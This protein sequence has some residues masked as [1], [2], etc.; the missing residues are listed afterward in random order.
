MLVQRARE[1]RCAREVQ[2]RWTGRR[3][4]STSLSSSSSSS[5]SSVDVS[6]VREKQ[7]LQ[8][9]W[10]GAR[11]ATETHPPIMCGAD[12]S[13]RRCADVEEEDVVLLR[14][15]FDAH[16][17]VHLDPSTSNAE[18]ACCALLRS[19]V[20]ATRESDWDALERLS[21][22]EDASLE[23]GFGLHPWWARERQAGWDDRLRAVLRRNP[24][25]IVG[26]IGL[27]KTS[28]KRAPARDW[29]EQLETFEISLDV[30]AEMRRAACL[31]CVKAWGYL[32]EDCLKRRTQHPKQQLPPRILL[33]SF[34]GSPETVHRIVTMLDAVNCDAYFGFSWVVNGA[35]RDA[36]RR[37]RVMETI[38]SVPATRLV[39]E[40]DLSV[41]GDVA[42]DLRRGL[43]LIAEARSWSLSE[44]IEKT[45]ANAA[46]FYQPVPVQ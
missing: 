35:A 2:R 28:G 13:T 36:K 9:R 17:H 46:N 32:I 12:E 31:H 10:C 43:K 19:G 24:A 34:S 20:M 21:T 29:E 15:V 7:T 14:E 6:F 30:A 5:S 18:T 44:T 3:D 33:H 8:R 27:D 37:E 11:T 45:A 39:L 42:G 1:L 16:S 25:A 26:E 4:T 22:C 41:A 38:R 40:S 23:L